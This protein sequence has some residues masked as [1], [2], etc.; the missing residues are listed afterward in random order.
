MRTKRRSRLRGWLVRRGW[1]EPSGLTRGRE[2]VHR[3]EGATLPAKPKRAYGK[4]RRL[5]F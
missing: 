5:D 3:S 2:R 4:P 1:A